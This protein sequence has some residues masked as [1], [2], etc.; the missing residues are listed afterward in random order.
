MPDTVVRFSDGVIRTTVLEWEVRREE[1]WTAKDWISVHITQIYS[2]TEVT[3]TKAVDCED[4]LLLE[5]S[6]PDWDQPKELALTRQ[7]SLVW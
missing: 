6:S 1:D 3:V 5:V 2:V 4:H 7:G